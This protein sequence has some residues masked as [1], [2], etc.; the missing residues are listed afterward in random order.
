MIVLVAT[1]QVYVIFSILMAIP[2]SKF[3]ILPVPSV[4]VVMAE[5]VVIVVTAKI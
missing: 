5:G 2:L 1:I 4:L 3:D